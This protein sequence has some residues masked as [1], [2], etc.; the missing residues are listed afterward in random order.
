MQIETIPEMR[1]TRADEQAIGQLLDLA[2]GT[3]FD[4][5]SYFQNRHHT[6]LLVRDGDQIIGHMAIG[7]RAIRMGDVLCTAAGLAEVA[8]HP[9][10]QRKGIA[11][12]M[13]QVAIA[14][15]RASVADFFILF[16]DEP[17]YA[18]AGFVPQPNET[19]S[20]SFHGVRTGAQERRTDDGLMV[21]ELGEL[22]WDRD[23]RIDLVGFA[24]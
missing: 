3:E 5:R 18:R 20:V 10:H 23:A 9:D 15:A 14:E 22:R 21:M 6:R 4:G 8:S 11:T 17:L 16:G 7:L 1:L 19:L 12:A 13:L 2:F 24:F